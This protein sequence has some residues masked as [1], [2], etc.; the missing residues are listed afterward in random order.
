MSVVRSSL[1]H[2]HDDQGDR[3]VCIVLKL[4]ESGQVSLLFLFSPL[5][6]LVDDT[7]SIVRKSN[8]NF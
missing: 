8:Y 5:S 6:L 4:R 1:R 3:C 2:H 7:D